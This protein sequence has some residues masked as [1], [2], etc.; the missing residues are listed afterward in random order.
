LRTSITTTAQTVIWIYSSS[1]STRRMINRCL[2][3]MKV[4]TA[5]SL[6]Q[7]KMELSSLANRASDTEIEYP[8]VV[9]V[10]GMQD[11]IDTVIGTMNTVPALRRTR[12]IQL[13]ARS[14]TTMHRVSKALPPS[15]ATSS[16]PAPPPSQHVVRCSKP[17]RAVAFLRCI[18]EVHASH[19]TLEPTSKVPLDAS[20]TSTPTLT[21]TTPSDSDPT[22]KPS[23]V[24][25]SIPQASSAPSKTSSFF[26]EAQLE[27]FKST[28]F[29]I[30]EGELS[31]F[32]K[33]RSIMFAHITL[34][35][36]VVAQRLRTFFSAH[37][38]RHYL[39][40]SQWSGN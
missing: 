20:A 32:A 6:D 38:N 15:E 31:K 18:A 27:T 16:T 29:L 19:L 33:Q 34:L 2:K 3:G 17:L 14:M 36:N 26:T 12:V 11:A 37:R 1:A 25:S 21:T 5:D 8:T 13:I 10:D 23:T 28:R 39:T 30:A 40:V 24:P 22:L 4:H 9:V 7:L 35:D